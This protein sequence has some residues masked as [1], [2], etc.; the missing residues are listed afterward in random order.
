MHGCFY[1]AAYPQDLRPLARDSARPLRRR[2]RAYLRWGRHTA[3]T[4]SRELLDAFGA[5]A[6]QER[7]WWSLAEQGVGAELGRNRL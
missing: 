6:N 7:R 4:G 5:F 1:S 2:V 3:W